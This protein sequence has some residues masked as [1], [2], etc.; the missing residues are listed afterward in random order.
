MTGGEALYA[1][2]GHFGA[3]PIRCGWF[4]FVLPALMLNYFGQGAVL[5]QHPAAVS[6]PFYLAVPEWAPYPDDRAG[7]GRRPRS[8]RRR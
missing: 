2:M 1:D 4:G 3:T 8:P 5:L 7:H 6:N